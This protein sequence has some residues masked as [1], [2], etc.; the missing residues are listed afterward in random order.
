MTAAVEL[1]SI[2][3]CLRSGIPSALA[4]CSPD[5]MPHISH[6]SAVQYLDRERVATSRQSF[7]GTSA[8]LRA[9]PFSQAIVARPT[10]GEQFR[11][12]LRYLHTLTEGEEFEAMRANLDAV[13]SQ[14]GIGSRV[15]VARPG[16]ASGAGLHAPAQRAAGHVHRAAG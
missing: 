9:N 10:T 8:G 16:R 14:T 2:R 4:T 13:A 1:E 15:P 12:D 11:L 7:N 3:D 6:I 5:G